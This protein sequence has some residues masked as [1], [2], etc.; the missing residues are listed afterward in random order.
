MQGHALRMKHTD[1]KLE[2]KN[3]P[4]SACVYLDRSHMVHRHSR[5]TLVLDLDGSKQRLEIYQNDAKEGRE[6]DA[7]MNDEFER[8]IRYIDRAGMEIGRLEMGFELVGEWGA[9]MLG[10]SLS[11]YLPDMRGLRR[12]S[13]ATTLPGTGG[14]FS[15]NL[16]GLRDRD[17]PSQAE[18]ASAAEKEAYIKNSIRSG[19]RELKFNGLEF[20]SNEKN[21]GAIFWTYIP[22]KGEQETSFTEKAICTI[23]A[24]DNTGGPSWTH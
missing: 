4:T 1:V 15:V 12:G 13:T 22:V 5:I 2:C 6:Q 9:L 20:G 24:R 17:D 23:R 14:E 11:D 18:R 21:F 16:R 3:V 10:R 7:R 8:F 19:E